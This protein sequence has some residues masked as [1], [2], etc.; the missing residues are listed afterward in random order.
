M[1]CFFLS[2][3]LALLL[4]GC[5][6]YRSEGR[7]QFEDNA[8]AKVSTPAAFQL[9]DCKKQGPL[10]T[11]FNEEFPSHIYELVV[12]ES[13]LEIWL[14]HRGSRV[15]VKAFQH[16]DASTHS[17]TYE[18]KNDTIWNLYKEQFIK[19]LEDNTMTLE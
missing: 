10:E 2:T 12:S 13:D 5:T 3:L 11:W 15:E 8:P 4:S 19:E 18:F 17:C 1:R 9:K 16:G 7:K 14:T 6:I